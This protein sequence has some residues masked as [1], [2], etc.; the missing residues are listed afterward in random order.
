M[1]IIIIKNNKKLIKT[2]T[3]M[4]SALKNQDGLG[5]LW[6][7]KWEVTF[8]D[9]A[10]YMQLKTTRPFIAHF[11][12]ATVGEVS[13]ANCH[14]FDINE[15]EILFQNGTVYGLGNKKKTDTQHMAEILADLPRK[16]WKSVLEMNDS[17]FV[18]ANLKKKTFQ[19][20]N[21]QDWT[22]KNKI[23]YSKN[24]VLD[25]TLIGVYGTL[26]KGYSNYHN[27][28]TRACYVGS[29]ETVDKYPMVI[30]GIPFLINRPGEGH[31]VDIDLFL[32]T[33]DQL[34]DIDML[35]GNPNW[36]ERKKAEV[37]TDK[38][39][40]FLPYIYFNDTRDTG[41]YHKTYTQQPIYNSYSG[42]NRGWDYVDEYCE[43]ENPQFIKDY[44]DEFCDICYGERPPQQDYHWQTNQWRHLK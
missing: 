4:A 44:G 9:S 30:D 5:I 2:E 15:D 13:K 34:M 43:C 11:R 33:G 10:D 37:I 8:H 7:D 29:G 25:M 22:T 16:R 27:Y 42:Y 12:Y 17:R 26:K 38:G 36:Y 19:V 3:L 39:N 6:L 14:P 18:T 32:V 1:C 23:M 35:E 31:N 24:N 21:K 40:V 41:V 28:L 20:Y